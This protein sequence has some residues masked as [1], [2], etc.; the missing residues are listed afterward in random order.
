MSRAPA[1]MRKA[2]ARSLRYLSVTVLSVAAVATAETVP[3]AM[4]DSMW[5]SEPPHEGIVLSPEKPGQDA[6][7]R[8]FLAAEAGLLKGSGGWGTELSVERAAVTP[9]EE[10][11]RDRD[12]GGWPIVGSLIGLVVFA[13]TGLA[14]VNSRK[15]WPKGLRGNRL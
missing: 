3:G 2:V 9:P 11:G 4:D 12:A 13:L 14:V 5:L 1:S 6:L 15:R 10:Q 8:E 7:S